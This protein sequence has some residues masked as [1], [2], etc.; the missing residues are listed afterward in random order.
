MDKGW[1]LRELGRSFIEQFLLR[2]S[3]GEE[4]VEAVEVESFYYNPHLVMVGRWGLTH[5]IW[6]ILDRWMWL[7]ACNVVC[8]RIKCD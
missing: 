6:P 7:I 5:F 4:K 3:V 1:F 2:T 8:K